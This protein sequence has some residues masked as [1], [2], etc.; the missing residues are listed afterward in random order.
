L[1]LTIYYFI[2]HY[3][4][5]KSS[6]LN[7]YEKIAHQKDIR[8]LI[9]GDSI[10]RGAG[11]KDRNLTWFK[12]W[13]Q[14]MNQHFG[15]KLN[16]H[17]LVQSGATAYEGLYLFKQAEKNDNIDLIFIVFGEN[18]RKYMK[19]NQFSSLY[20][21]LIKEVKN[22]YPNAE[23]M[24]ITESCLAHQS[25]AHTILKL[26]NQYQTSHI[27]MREPFQH[28]KLP[29][30]QLTSDLIHP[31]SKGYQ[32]YA[33]AMYQTINEGIYKNKQISK[34]PTE[35]PP[36]SFLEISQYH[37]KNGEFYLLNEDQVTNEYD[38]SI[39][40]RFTGNNVGVKVFVGQD[41]GSIDVF[42][43]KHYIRTLSTFWPI[44]K[45]RVLYVESNLPEGEHEVTFIFSKNNLDNTSIKN[46]N[47]QISSIM[48]YK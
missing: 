30:E 17:S 39:S 5:A 44:P 48:V 22:V 46:P 29:V 18:D 26:S 13:E 20:E 4:E 9:I 2:S 25:F 3:K 45:H 33:M 24:T 1:S 35:I 28:S 23:I 19:A 37:E 15:I 12:Q 11:V 42:I 43:D 34:Q 6:T 31:N 36:S 21:T 10:G 40:Y 32:L 38:A 47:M 14:L 7:V 27:D 16:R 41:K 8:Y